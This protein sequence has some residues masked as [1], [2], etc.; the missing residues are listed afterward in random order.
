MNQT[1]L[2]VVDSR[3]AADRRLAETAVF[4]ALDHFGVPW[5]VYELG[6]PE[7]ASDFAPTTPRDPMAPPAARGAAERYAGDRALVILAHDG[8]GRMPAGMARVVA[9]AVRAGAGL[10]SF[11]RRLDDWPASLRALAP[12]DLS[13]G[14]ADRLIVDDRANPFLVL[15]H[16]PGEELA[17]QRPIQVITARAVDTTPVLRTPDGRAAVWTRMAGAGRVVLCG[18]G[19]WLFDEAVLGHGRGIS[20]LMWRALVWAARKPFATRGMPPFLTARFDDC[21]GSYDAFGYVR[22]LNAIGI[23]PNLGL[24][25]D[26]LGEADWRAAGALSRR[27]GADFSMHAFRDDLLWHDPGWSPCRPMRRKPRFARGA[28]A[29]LTMDHWTGAARSAAALARGFAAMDRAFARH[30]LRHSRILNSHFA[31]VSFPALPRFL[32][33]GVDILVNNGVSGQLYGNQPVWRP[34]PFALRGP[35][36]SHPLVIDDSPDHT[37]AFCAGVAAPTTAA[38]S[39]EGDI[40]WGHT[41]FLKEHRRV[42]VGR[43]AARAI[44]NMEWALD[45]MAWGM[46]VAHEQR[47]ACVPP[48]DWRRLVDA[49]ARHW[50][51]RDIQFAGREEVASVTH[52]L[53]HSRLVGARLERGGLTADL[54]GQ[55]DGPSPLT[56][57]HNEGRGCRRVIHTVPP[58]AGYRRVAGLGAAAAQ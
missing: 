38:A 16:A 12:A 29:G 49:V 40:L 4:A 23:R 57:W 37:G 7:A 30:G 41:P 24:F 20:G 34:R 9:A 10:V 55:T 25:L 19:A 56:V 21:T 52:R 36:G 32:A 42:D 1:A 11:D 28:Y 31:E 43:A 33:R 46:L 27:G 47:V 13:A 54:T 58:I 6:S 53:F 50:R 45:A 48:N 18:C 22:P 5:N 14:R 39:M 51:G 35:A 3:R 26:E 17:L 8:A 44:R 2:V 15:P